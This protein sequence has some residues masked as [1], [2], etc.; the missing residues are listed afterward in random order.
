MFPFGKKKKKQTDIP[1]RK[2]FTKQVSEVLYSWKRAV[3]SIPS[4]L[5]LMREKM[6]D[7]AKTNAD[8]GMYYIRTG[9]FN[10]AVFRFKMALRFNP[11]YAPAYYGFGLCRHEEGYHTEAEE[12][13]RKALSLK[14]DYAEAEYMLYL[15][16]R[17]TLPGK[18]PL[19]VIHDI[20]DP[21]ASIY[22][23][24]YVGEKNYEGHEHIAR[25]LQTWVGDNE[26]KPDILDIGCGTG[27]CGQLLKEKKLANTLVGVD[28]SPAMLTEAR[29][30]V[31]N[32]KPVYS[33]LAEQDYMEFLQH[34]EKKYD[35]V[36]AA[37]S[38]HYM[39]DL[40]K[41]F[42][43]CKQVLNPGGALFVTLAKSAT[44]FTQLLSEEQIFAYPAAALENAAKN[45]G[46]QLHSLEE[47]TLYDKVPGFIGVFVNNA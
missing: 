8:L 25:A 29:N 33:E 12:L 1:P 43:A 27:L 18:V 39:K 6:K 7:L 28:I 5:Q 30:L 44:N 17:K 20:F 14:H 47:V 46:L 24:T 2:P 4:E 23:L 35:A 11:N 36:V 21:M 40:Q 16:D 9:Q 32:Y 45:S 37:S 26:T 19:D 34:A 22:N 31:I 38:L 15:Y 41:P 3:E 13:F 42:Q 10:D